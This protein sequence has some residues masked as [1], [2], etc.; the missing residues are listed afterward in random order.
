M[1]DP[2]DFF[3]PPKNFLLG[4]LRALWWLAWDFC[5]ETIGWS[6]GWL[7]LRL[8][9]FGRFPDEPLSGVDQASTGV[10]L[11]VQLVGLGTLAGFIWFLSGN[12][13]GL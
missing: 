12:W 1:L 13:P 4:I 7:M 3:A 5:V 10:A 2:S 11:F 9:T 8:V 6:I